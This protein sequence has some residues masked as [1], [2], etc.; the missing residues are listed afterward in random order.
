MKVM[1]PYSC[2]HGEEEIDVPFPFANHIELD[3][4]Y[5][6]EYLRVYVDLDDPSLAKYPDRKA[7]VEENGYFLWEYPSS[8]CLECGSD[9]DRDEE[10]NI[11][12]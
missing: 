11:L 1:I 9:N 5:S 2:G 4:D 7:Q 10:G 6:G 12:V 8:E 3:A